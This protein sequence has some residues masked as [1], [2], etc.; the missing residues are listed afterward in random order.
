MFLRPSVS[1]S[2]RPSGR[3][4]VRPTVQP[5]ARPLARPPGWKNKQSHV[6]K[7]RATHKRIMKA[8]YDS[9]RKLKPTPNH[10]SN[11]KDV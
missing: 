9:I 1:P 8:Q 10:D 11:Q 2:V 5:S 4:A 6:H 3:P 7:V